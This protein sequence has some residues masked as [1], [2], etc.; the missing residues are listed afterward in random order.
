[1]DASHSAMNAVSSHPKLKCQILLREGVCAAGS[2]LEGLLEVDSRTDVGLGL[3]SMVVE[4]VGTEGQSRTTGSS[5]DTVRATRRM[6]GTLSGTGDAALG[7]RLR[8]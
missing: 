3:G 8:R 2:Y 4:L 1:M 6:D 5:L 7:R